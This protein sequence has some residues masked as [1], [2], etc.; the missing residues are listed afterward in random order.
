METVT[1]EWYNGNPEEIIVVTLSPLTWYIE[2]WHAYM[3]QNYRLKQSVNNRLRSVG[4]EAAYTMTICDHLF[5]SLLTF[6]L[7][8]D[9][10]MPDRRRKE[11]GTAIITE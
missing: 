7:S 6:S 1:G 2:I 3:A 9:H 11:S 10:E 5:V 4:N 8:D